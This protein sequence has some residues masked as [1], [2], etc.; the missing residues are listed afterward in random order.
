M[1]LNMNSPEYW[2]EPR[3]QWPRPDMTEKLLTGMLHLNT[4]E[5]KNF[6]YNPSGPNKT[7]ISPRT[8][9]TV[10]FNQGTPTCMHGIFFAML[11][12]LKLKL[13]L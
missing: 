9:R 10:N 11:L 13:A 6:F 8:S 1:S 2:L 4:N 3:K 7:T 5:Q 12:K